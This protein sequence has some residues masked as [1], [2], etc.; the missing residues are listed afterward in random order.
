MA[1]GRIRHPIRAI[2]E[3]GVL[4]YGG[5]K[6]RPCSHEVPGPRRPGTGLTIIKQ[7]PLHP[8]VGVTKLD[9]NNLS[10]LKSKA[11]LFSKFILVAPFFVEPG[12]ILCDPP[13]PDHALAD[14]NFLYSHG[15]VAPLPTVETMELFDGVY[16]GRENEYLR[17]G[18]VSKALKSASGSSFGEALTSDFSLR[19]LSVELTDTLKIDTVPICETQLPESLPEPTT[20]SKLCHNVLSAALKTLPLPD[21]TC[22]WEDILTFKA[23]LHDKRWEF[24]R[25]LQTLATKVQSEA[26]L[27]D[28]IEWMVNE[29]T[30]AMQIHH[31]KA[32]QSFVDIFF[33]SPLEVI[34]NLVKL[35][36]SKIAKGA[37]SVRKRKVELLEAE[38]KAPGREC[39]YVF[40]ARERFDRPSGLMR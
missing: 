32:S 37:L 38:M 21:E 10:P 11:L 17:A 5:D 15:I 18:G 33:I 1:F 40:E 6:T 7:V 2:G 22:S 35:N 12:G 28:E 30:K 26:E 29:Y 31:I 27:R 16:T 9:I 39:A 23:E 3:Y 34:E 14:L 24:Q 19:R 4:F 25:F 8:L 20:S 13:P 36:W